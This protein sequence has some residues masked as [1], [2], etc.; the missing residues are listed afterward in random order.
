MTK[1]QCCLEFMDKIDVDPTDLMTVFSLR[2]QYRGFLNSGKPG[3]LSDYK[4]MLET[5]DASYPIAI[6]AIKRNLN[7]I[8]GKF[9]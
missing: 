1:E 8:Q 3:K 2:N 6:S 9:L 4:K 7:Y 5:I